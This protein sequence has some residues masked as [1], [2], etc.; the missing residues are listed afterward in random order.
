MVSSY[1]LIN[2]WEKGGTGSKT[3]L[4]YPPPPAIFQGLTAEYPCKLQLILHRSS[5]QDKKDCGGKGKRK[6]SRAISDTTI[7]ITLI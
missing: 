2:S 3:K 5:T 7:E 6:D 4:L 1:H